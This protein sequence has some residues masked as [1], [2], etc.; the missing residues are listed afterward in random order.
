[1]IELPFAEFRH[2]VLTTRERVKFADSDPCGHL[3]SR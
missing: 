1:M 3:A 2:R